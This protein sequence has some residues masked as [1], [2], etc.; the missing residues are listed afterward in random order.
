MVKPP[1]NKIINSS[2]S[3]NL[4][5]FKQFTKIF[6]SFFISRLAISSAKDTGYKNSYD[7]LRKHNF[8][9]LIGGIFIPSNSLQNIYHLNIPL[10]SFIE[11][12]LIL[13]CI[14]YLPTCREY[15]YSDRYKELTKDLD[16]EIMSIDYKASFLHL[17]KFTKAFSSY[18]ID[19]IISS[20]VN[21]YGYGKLDNRE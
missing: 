6:S 10:F 11:K 21:Y 16:L 15:I 8:N 7:Y 13:D 17:R 3:S 20:F 2:V 9:S 4:S 14:S 18:N 5:L 1:A 19:S 12:Y